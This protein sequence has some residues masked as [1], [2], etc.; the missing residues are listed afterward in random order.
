MIGLR[1]IVPPLRERGIDFAALRTQQQEVVAGA[2]PRLFE[3]AERSASDAFVEAR[4]QGPDFLHVG[5]EAALDREVFGLG[6]EHIVGRRE[7]GRQG[8]HAAA[9]ALLP[10]PAHLR[11]EQRGEQ[12]TR[13]GRLVGADARV[14]AGQGRGDE[15]FAIGCVEHRVEQRQ[16]AFVQAFGAQAFDGGLGAAAKQQLEDFVEQ[17]RLGHTVDEVGAIGDRRA[18]GVVDLEAEFGREAHRAQHAH[19]VFAVAR[20]GM[21]DDAQALGFDVADAAVIVEH[22]LGR[23]V[24]EH[25]VD[26]EIAPRGVF[27]LFAEDV[28]AQQAPGFVG[29]ARLRDRQHFARAVAPFAPGAERLVGAR[30]ALGLLAAAF[31]RIGG[32]GGGFGFAGAGQGTEGRDFDDLVAKAH[33]HDLEAP[34]D[35][36]RASEQRLH[37]FGRRV[38]GDV[39]ILGFL[40]DQQVAHRA[41]DHIGLVAGLLQRVRDAGGVIGNRAR[42]DAELVGAVDL[43][44]ARD[45]GRAGCFGL[46][47]PEQSID[48]FADHA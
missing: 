4:L 13:R 22:G 12:E 9:F 43:G 15:A 18:R 47:A 33:M 5:H 26:G 10:E 30:M 2:K 48:E 45:L 29:R 42:I 16:Q 32:R 11:P 46:A 3:Q 39:E 41:A 25:R 31:I 14:G 36:A 38:G 23:R 28:V 34:P 27:V 20:L 19:R 35:D 7:Q 8:R 1:E 21:A 37:L 24:V 6:R 44:L 40:A 17:P